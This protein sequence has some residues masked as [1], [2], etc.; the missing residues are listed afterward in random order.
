[1]GRP[2]KYRPLPDQAYDPRVTDLS[3][4]LNV[5]GSSGP[6]ATYPYTD[7]ATGLMT[8]GADLAAGNGPGTPGY[9]KTG[10]NGSGWQNRNV[11]N[12]IPFSLVAGVSARVLP[13]NYK[14]T[15]L[16][17]QNLDA[18]AVLN[19]SFGND[20]QGFGAQI[21]AGGSALFDFTTPP[22]TLYLFCATANIQALVMEI[23]RA[24]A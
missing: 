2:T 22:D 11:T 24:G 4:P 18:T 1:M 5:P 10:P 6:Q 19:F 21:G 16:L 7:A 9:Q 8:T 12:T 13:V 17:L 14:R 15:G 23:S 3:S 20:L